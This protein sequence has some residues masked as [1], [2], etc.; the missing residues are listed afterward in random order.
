M[1]AA[2]ASAQYWP[3]APDGYR[4]YRGRAVISE[5]Y[6]VCRRMGYALRKIPRG[7]EEF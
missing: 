1:S 3:T 6:S 4:V 2:A 7:R 5:G